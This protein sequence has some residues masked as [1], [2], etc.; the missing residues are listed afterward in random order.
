MLANGVRDRVLAHL[1]AGGT[2]VLWKQFKLGRFQ[3]MPFDAFDNVFS[4]P[5]WSVYNHIEPPDNAVLQRFKFPKL[6]FWMPTPYEEGNAFEETRYLIDARGLMRWLDFGELRRGDPSLSRNGRLINENEVILVSGLWVSY[7]HAPHLNDPRKRH[8]VVGWIS[9]LHF[10]AVG[11]PREGQQTNG[12]GEPVPT[13][14][15]D[16]KRRFGKCARQIV[17]ECAPLVQAAKQRKVEI[18]KLK[19]KESKPE[20]LRS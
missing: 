5:T 3:D 7:K 1:R 14:E 16:L 15:E 8:R 13:N 2:R 10:N 4:T 12:L 17:T 9:C 18:L 20:M 6:K 19:K 11:D